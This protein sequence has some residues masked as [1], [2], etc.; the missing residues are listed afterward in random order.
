MKKKL[1]KLNITLIT[2]IV[3]LSLSLIVSIIYN[4]IGGFYYNRIIKYESMLGE[5]QEIIVTGNGAFAKS[6][7]FSGA[8]LIDKNFKQE[9]FISVKNTT[10]PV[11]LRAS[12]NISGF[13]NK[14]KMKGVTNWIIAEDGYYYLNQSVNNLEK[15]KLCEYLMY[16]LDIQLNGNKDYIMTFLIEASYNEW[17]YNAL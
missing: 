8:L 12:S 6:C 7:N 11:Y 4:F 14:V 10:L 3:V 16:D 15:I 2:L 5:K 9:V 1:N 17:E 13:Q